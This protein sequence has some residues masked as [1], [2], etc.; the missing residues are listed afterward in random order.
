MVLVSGHSG[1]FRWISLRMTSLLQQSDI[2]LSANTEPTTNRHEQ[3][4][5]QH[6]EVEECVDIPPL[7]VPSLT[8]EELRVGK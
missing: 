6:V 3:E 4:R 5:R 7:L 8:T 2:P 1:W